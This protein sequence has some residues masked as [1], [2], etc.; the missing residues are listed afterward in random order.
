MLHLTFVL[1]SEADGL[2][3]QSGSSRLKKKHLQAAGIACVS[4][5]YLDIDSAALG[6]HQ[7]TVDLLKQRLGI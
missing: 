6:G 4:L 3:R 2:E 5:S 7:G 1:V